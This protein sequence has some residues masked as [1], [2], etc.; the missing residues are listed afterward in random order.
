M[1]AQGSG[2]RSAAILKTQFGTRSGERIN[3]CIDDG[4]SRLYEV[5]DTRNAHPAESLLV[6]R[7]TS[8]R[9]PRIADARAGDSK[10]ADQR[11]VGLAAHFGRLAVRAAF[12]TL[13][14]AIARL[15]DPVL[16]IGCAAWDRAVHLPVEFDLW[17]AL[18]HR[19]HRF[20]KLRL[21]LARRRAGVAAH[22]EI[23]LSRGRG[24]GRP[25]GPSGA[26]R[27]D[28]ALGQHGAR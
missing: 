10:P 18:A 13:P 21:H 8:A 28:M 26:Q 1:N 17:I 9:R 19:A 6:L 4:A 7:G 16:R 5:T 12:H 15:N 20:R 22:V 27:R 2:S 11:A 24:E 3:Y 25:L 23:D 14:S